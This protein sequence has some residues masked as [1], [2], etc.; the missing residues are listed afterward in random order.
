VCGR[1][2]EE[3]P[4]SELYLRYVLGEVPWEELHRFPERHIRCNPVLAQFIVHPRFDPIVAEGAFAKANLD[5][6]YVREE[7][8]RV[9]SG[10]ERLCEVAA[11]NLPISE[12]PLAH[13]RARRLGPTSEYRR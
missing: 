12:Y 13:H 9:T 4:D 8:L 7:E 2:V 6:D 5:A 1:E 10:H 11:L 3:L